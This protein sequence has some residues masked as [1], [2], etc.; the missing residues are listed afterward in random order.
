MFTLRF[1]A[2]RLGET[3]IYSLS[4]RMKPHFLL[5]YTGFELSHFFTSATEA[6]SHWQVKYF[7]ES[8]DIFSIF[9]LLTEL[10]NSRNALRELLKLFK[11]TFTRIEGLP[12]ST[13]E[14]ET[15][16]CSQYGLC[17]LYL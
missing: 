5:F 14:V 4:S 15:L 3:L 8:I 17:V 11:Q 12:D 6:G 1:L 10:E 9:S 7:N 13:F 2:A 16:N